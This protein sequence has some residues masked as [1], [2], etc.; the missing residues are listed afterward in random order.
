MKR[1]STIVS[2]LLLL[3]A[4]L[5][6]Q[7]TDANTN[8]SI[9][10]QKEEIEF[11]KGDRSNPVKVRRIIETNYICNSYRTNFTVVD[12]YNDQESIDDI[13]IYTNGDRNRSI[14]PKSDYYSVADIFYSDARL[15]YF[16]MP[17]D[18]KGSIGKV[19]ITK[20]VKDPRFFTQVFFTD[21]YDIGLKEVKITIPSWMKTDLKEF[22]FEGLNVDIKIDRGNPEKTVYTYTAKNLKARKDENDAPGP[23]FVYPHLLVL[24]RSADLGDQKLTYFSNFTEQYKWYR[25][26]VLAVGNDP[27]SIKAKATEITKGLSDDMEKIMAIYFWVQDNVRY[28]AFENGIAGFK[29]S[30]AQTVL[31]KKYGDCKG[32][33][34]L[35][36]ELLVS[37]GFDAR[38]CWIGTSHIAYDS[39]TPS[40]CVHNHMICALFYKG[41]R[42]FLDATEKNIGFSQYAE[43][44]Q[45]RQVMIEDGDHCIIDRV[46]ATDFLQNTEMET[47]KLKIE[48]TA[49]KGV[50]EHSYAGES[51]EEILSGIESIKK[52]N[53]E[54]ALKQYLSENNKD[55][56]LSNLTIKNKEQDNKPL[57][58]NYDIIH[59]N[60]V[61]QFGNELYIDMDFR[62][63]LSNLKLDTAERK[64]DYVMSYKMHLVTETILD[65]PEGYHAANLPSA[66]HYKHPAF[67]MS[68]NY[69][70]DKGKLVYRK[71]IDFMRV[72][73]SKKEFGKLNEAI[74]GLNNF[75]NAQVTLTK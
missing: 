54:P 49:L 8:I 72:K 61:S 16:N 69:N 36:K 40:L 56:Q 68:L 11:I 52:D 73:I 74:E 41:K 65:I 31:Q 13:A 9:N 58:L 60:A 45:G 24:S 17:M 46:P 5:W 18:K 25:S 66:F 21:S 15:I 55:Y 28:I 62:K 64:Q 57:E 4:R 20:T 19:V 47:R 51:K 43:R 26:L 44:I 6:S 70:T 12:V 30:P 53:L 33:A 50:V 48:G 37:Q 2:C 22:N 67:E 63:E 3:S 10:S 71:E 29:P 1:F 27:A 75:Y 59:Q 38:L 32:M 7:S 42:Y 23:T 34:N 14:V 35:T 39:S